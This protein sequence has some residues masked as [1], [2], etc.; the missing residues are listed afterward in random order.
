MLARIL[1]FSLAFL[2]P[3]AGRAVA[4]S[5]NLQGP[6]SG[7]VYFA[8]SRSV[9]PLLG[10][11]GATLIGPSLLSQ[12]DWASVAPGGKRAL[13]S[14]AGSVRLVSG[15]PEGEPAESSLRLIEAIDRVTWSR[16][17]TFAALYSS[18]TGQLQRVRFADSDAFADPPVELSPMGPASTL[19]I[20][21]A[22]QQIAFGVAGSGLYLLHSGQ[23]PVLLSSMAHPAGA[24]FDE[25]G[26]RLYAIDLDTKRILEFDSG[27]G[28]I[29]FAS[30]AETDG[31]S[32]DP[33]GLAVSAGGRYLL[34]ADR[35]SRS[36]RVYETASG[37]LAN[38]IRL[39]IAP[40][41]FEALSGEPS[42]LLNG[43]RPG[44]WLWILNASQNP[45][46]YFVP[47]SMEEQL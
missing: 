34:L 15:L 29:E 3:L 11:P 13:V 40:S 27:S 30:L 18:A 10:V 5:A 32:L 28:A 47:A 33:V 35:I 45:E 43:D 16:G 7:Y 2:L 42:F 26:R 19:A 12:V 44:D 25:S 22:G 23:S 4:Q 31:P 21:P 1:R 39:D 37:R 38:T 36:V 9:R 8:A 41:R 20:E 17:G 6:V 24:A 14:R 46:V